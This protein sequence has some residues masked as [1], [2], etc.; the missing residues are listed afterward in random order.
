MKSLL[1]LVI[2]VALLCGCETTSQNRPDYWKLR[3]AMIQD[4]PAEQ[5][6]YAQIQLVR[7]MQAQQNF[8]TAERNERWAR[9]GAIL[10]QGGQDIRDRAAIQQT[11]AIQQSMQIINQP[12]PYIA[13]PTYTPRPTF[14][15]YY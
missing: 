8:D 14:P 6:P 11:Q 2:S 13:S 7:D 4:L 3:Q 12:N 10:A 1:L 15:A 5:R 9:A